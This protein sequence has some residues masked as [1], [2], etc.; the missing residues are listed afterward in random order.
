MEI[1]CGRLGGLVPRLHE[2]GYDAVGIDPLAPEGDRYRQ[3]EFEQSDVAEPVDAVIA[4]TS[5]HHVR[6][7]GDVLDKAANALT[8]DGRVIVVE[9]DWQRFDEQTARWCFERL[10]QTGPEGWLHRRRDEWMASG[11][12][13]DDLFPGWAHQHGLHSV[14]R[15]VEE[16]DRRFERVSCTRGAYFFPELSETSEADEL[17]AISSGQIRSARVD[18]VGRPA[19]QERT[20]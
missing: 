17:E 14:Q 4:S 18:Y 16:L 3:I 9:W 6:E 11:Q 15:L 20:A 19:R 10:T 8:A 13:W 12:P 2:S 7:P 5:L 1:G